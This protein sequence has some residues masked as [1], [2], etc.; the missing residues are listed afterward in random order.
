MVGH[1]L[2]AS[3]NPFRGQTWLAGRMLP[4]PALGHTNWHTI[5]KKSQVVILIFN[6]LTTIQLVKPAEQ[7][8]LT[9]MLLMGALLGN[10]SGAGKCLCMAKFVLCSPEINPKLYFQLVACTAFIYF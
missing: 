8:F 9:T 5:M 6:T 7:I 1:S 10:A 2:Q 4:M 3:Q